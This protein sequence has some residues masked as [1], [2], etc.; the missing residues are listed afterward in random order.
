MSSASD[1]P[2]L[3]SATAADE[4]FLRQVYAAS[5]AAELANVPWSDEQKDAFLRFQ[6]D[7]QQGHYQ[8]H[9]PNASYQVILS[10]DV[11]V[12]RLYVDRRDDEIRILDIAVLPRHQRNGVG[13]AILRELL[14]E[15][16]AG[17]KP[18]R[19]HVESYQSSASL[20]ERLGFVK[21]ED[22]GVSVLMEW[23]P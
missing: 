21:R 13:G 1:G 10:D 8:Q 19:I 14:A 17:H 4:P 2:R 3:R 22:H 15:A 11:P 6:F 20:F 18:I 5:R 16:D 7:A 9:Y 12:G 23:S